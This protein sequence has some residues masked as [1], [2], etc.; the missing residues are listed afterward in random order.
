MA[1]LKYQPHIDGLRGLSVIAVVLYHS[2][3]NI[4]NWEIFSGGYIGVD[5]FF[6]ISGYLITKI[7]LTEIFV[8]KNFSI[9]SFLKRRIRR[10]IPILFFVLLTFLLL[11]YLFLVPKD[12]IFLSEQ[13]LSQI[14]FL[15]NYFFWDYRFTYMAENSLL[16][17]FLHTWSLS[18]EEQFYLFFPI[19]LLIFRKFIINNLAK[20]FIV[21]IAFSLIVT[22]YLS[23]YHS[24]F[25]FF[26]TTSRVWEFLIGAS[27]AYMSIKKIKIKFLES[28]NKNLISL[29]SLIILIFSFFVFDENSKHPSVITLIPVISTIF[30]IYYFNKNTIAYKIISSYPLVNIGVISYSLY[31]WHFPIFAFFRKSYFAS[32]YDHNLI[33]IF[34]IILSF[35]L[36]F[37]SYQ[38]IE[39][40]FRFII[41]NF[42]ITSMFIILLLAALL[43]FS[44][45]ALNHNGYPKRL[46]LS[47]LQSKYLITSNSI[48]HYGEQVFEKEKKNVFIFGNSH[49]AEFKSILLSNNKIKENLNI[50]Y[51]PIQ[52]SSLEKFLSTKK[53]DSKYFFQ[54]F[55]N[56]KKVNEKYDEFVKTKIVFIKTRFSN[57]DIQ[58]L[59]EVIK[60]L[61]LM[62][63]KVI[64]FSTNPE[65]QLNSRNIDNF[66]VS[67]NSI[68]RKNFYL[69]FH[70]F[71]RF[72][73]ENDKLPNENEVKKISNQYF[74]SIQADYITKNRKLKRIA[75]ENNIVFLDLNYIICK[76]EIDSC[77]FMTENQLPL[78]ADQTGHYTDEG[79]KFL[80]NKPE[81][82]NKIFSVIKK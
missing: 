81:F 48:D 9:F 27:F 49:G 32:L 5:V 20:I 14:I 50:N 26:S 65:F 17:P 12:I 1:K 16:I 6:V 62:N 38:L 19:C 66:F 69:K 76:F 13:A 15:S 53:D 33:M 73:L 3:F 10:I 56:K 70:F 34:L 58:S 23:L 51:Y 63:K 71:E 4:F 61:K 29:T 77:D 46:K 47:E 79:I 42:K 52:I 30:L 39:R 22:S 41:K 60:K 64:L 18:V 54:R 7:I 35:L 31:L 2:K 36:S 21:L 8:E 11:S 45:K 40:R 43:I 72:I 25:N 68:L 75:K 44:F 55:S 67:D 82:E 37:L 80:G 59:S 57:E 24:N 28:L 74:Q 78:V